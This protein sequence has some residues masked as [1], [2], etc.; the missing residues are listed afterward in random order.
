VN[1]LLNYLICL[2]I[3]VRRREIV[4][5]GLALA[6]IGSF[7]GCLGR[8]EPDSEQYGVQF[9]TVIDAVD[10]LGMDPTGNSSIDSTLQKSLD[11]GNELIAFPPGEYLVT[12]GVTTESVS[13][14]GIVG[15]GS[16]PSDVRFIHTSNDGIFFINTDGGDGQLIKNVTMDYSQQKTGTIGIALRGN[17]NIFVIDIHYVGFDPISAN[18]DNTNLSVQAFNPDGNA[19]AEGVV[20]TGPSTIASHASQGPP[21]NSAFFWLGNKHQGTLKI[22]NW[23]IENTGGNA[24]YASRTNG[25][26]QVENS[27]FVNNNQSSVRISGDDC[28]CR[29]CTFIIDTDNDHP[30]NEYAEGDYINPNAMM[31]ESGNESNSGAL[32]TGCEFIYRSR[33]ENP[34]TL[35]AVRGL[36]SIGDF[37]VRDTRFVLDTADTMAIFAEDPENPSFGSTASKPWNV[38]VDSVSITGS[39]DSPHG[40]IELNNRPDSVIT[41]SC[42]QLSGNLDGIVITN[43]D[44]CR[45][46]DA[47]IDVGG[48]KIVSS[49]SAIET[50]N[51]TTGRSC[52]TPSSSNNIT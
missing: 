30:D 35:R 45:V 14:W 3:I 10:D 39:A 13:N 19:L 44:G 43:S 47:N 9:G 46:E 49:N 26:V 38:T 25:T 23:H 20:R 6:G 2:F 41:N 8:R 51:L 21:S 24:I 52:P 17:D 18:G 22:S 15:L 12:E 5:G 7:A 34:R 37:E 48:Q 4:E 40:A 50:S 11:R 28:Y 16:D 36:G 33:P 1:P 32:I 31:W 27:K 42:L 29:N